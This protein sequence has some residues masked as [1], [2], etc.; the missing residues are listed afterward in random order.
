MSALAGRKKR[1][2]IFGWIRRLILL[3]LFGAAGAGGW[4]IWQ[5]YQETEILR[6]IV[7]RLTAE[8]KVAEV[9]VEEYLTAQGGDLEKIRLKILEY[10][11][12][13]K[14]LKPIFCDFSVNDIIHFEALV[15]RLNDELVMDG[16]GK[17]IYLFRRAYA[18]NDKGNTYEACTINKPME[19]PQGYKIP[20]SDSR[21]SQIERKTWA[22]FWKYALDEKSREAAGVKNAQ[23]ESPATRFIPDKIYRLILEHDGGLRIQ[24]SDVPQILKGEHAKL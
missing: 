4:W 17:S 8:E 18:L 6:K 12:L 11:S 21:A 22:L 10:D 5:D 19:V 16:E 1:V 7:S 15:V 3:A 2:G 20:G 9:W 24:A 23:I 13:G 14:P